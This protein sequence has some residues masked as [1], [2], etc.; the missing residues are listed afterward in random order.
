MIK[1]KRR[2]SDTVPYT[3]PSLFSS[4]ISQVEPGLIAPPFKNIAIIMVMILGAYEESNLLPVCIDGV[5]QGRSH[6][7]MMRRSIQPKRAQRRTI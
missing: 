1:M 7:T 3:F 6:L 5:S 4:P 2:M